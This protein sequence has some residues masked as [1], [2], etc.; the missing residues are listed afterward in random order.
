MS[1][2]TDEEMICEQIDLPMNITQE[3]VGFTVKQWHAISGR[4]SKE[5]KILTETYHNVFQ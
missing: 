5:L 1:H 2:N 4:P 3:P